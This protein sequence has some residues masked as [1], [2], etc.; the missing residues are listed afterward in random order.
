MANI[1]SLDLSL[2]ESRK[3]CG[4]EITR[5]PLG[6]FLRAMK[7]LQDF[8][9][10]LAEA[11]FPGMDLQDVLLALKTGNTGIMSRILIRACTVAPEHALKLIAELTGIPMERLENDP[12][13]SLDG[14]GE[15]VEAWVEVN[16]LVNFMQAAT[17]LLQKFRAQKEMGGSTGFNT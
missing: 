3:V 5:A 16:R 12:Q 8:P 13:I 17:G 2:P 4:Y 15:I 14:L 10:Q 6:A 11:V 9:A 7:Q 1:D